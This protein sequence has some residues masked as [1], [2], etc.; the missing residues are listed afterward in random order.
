MYCDPIQIMSEDTRL[1]WE[2]C[3]SV[4]PNRMSVLCCVCAP[5]EESVTRKK[6]EGGNL[7]SVWLGSTKISHTR[8]REMLFIMLEQNCLILGFLEI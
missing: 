1:A 7:T 8:K 3:R 6:A 5:R 2:K 4:Q